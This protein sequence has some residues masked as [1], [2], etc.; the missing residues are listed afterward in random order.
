MK[1]LAADGYI[2]CRGLL[3]TLLLLHDPA[4]NP[5]GFAVLHLVT[6]G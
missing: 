6:T 4:P 3:R 1:V 2:V 5:L